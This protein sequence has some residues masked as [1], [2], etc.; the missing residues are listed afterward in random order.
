LAAK[1]AAAIEE[2]EA[3]AEFARKLSA[4]EPEKVKLQAEECGGGGGAAALA[5][6]YAAALAADEQM[7]STMAATAAAGRD[8]WMAATN[9]GKEWLP[10]APLA[11]KHGFYDERYRCATMAAIDMGDDDDI[12]KLFCGDEEEQAS[13]RLT[14]AFKGVN[15]DHC[16][17]IAK[18]LIDPRCRCK[19]LWLNDNK[20]RHEGAEHLSRA[21]VQNTTLIALY[22]NY[23]GIGDLG[24][25]HLL[26]ALKQNKTLLKLELGACCI[27]ELEEKN[28]NN[29]AQMVLEA[30]KENKKIEHIGLFGNHDNME[31]DLPR[32]YKELEPRKDE[33]EKLLMNEAKT[34]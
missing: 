6:G 26:G 29:A 32:I 13:E 9:V 28:E 2:E 33:R 8:K 31:D 27:G 34:S 3:R 14:L 22:L 17:V 20:I 10:C 7:N 24:L 1:M 11:P 15:D 5:A 12:E 21:L 16:K 25:Q 19:Q 23:N 4:M 18:F 30:L